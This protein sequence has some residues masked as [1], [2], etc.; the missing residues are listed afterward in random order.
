MLETL[1]SSSIISLVVAAALSD[2]FIIPIIRTLI[3]TTAIVGAELP[4]CDNCIVQI[5]AF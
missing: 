5:E 1:L 3:T 2:K 4:V